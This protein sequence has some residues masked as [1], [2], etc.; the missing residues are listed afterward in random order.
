MCELLY[1]GHNRNILQIMDK[2]WCPKCGLSYR[3]NTFLTSEEWTPI[4]DKN[5]WSQRVRYSEAP[6]YIYIYICQSVAGG[7]RPFTIFISLPEQR[8]CREDYPCHS[9]HYFSSGWAGLSGAIQGQYYYL[10][11]LTKLGLYTN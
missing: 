6:L 2:L 1:K 7:W 8:Y 5:D 4:M 11:N 9:N 3:A 10:S